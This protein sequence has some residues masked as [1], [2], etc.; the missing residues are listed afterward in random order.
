MKYHYDIKLN[1][2]SHFFFSNVFDEN[3]TGIWIFLRRSPI[4][5]Y[6]KHKSGPTKDGNHFKQVKHLV[7]GRI[8]QAYNNYLADILGVGLDGESKNSGF[9]SNQ[10]F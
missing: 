9:S 4:K 3:N 5:L 6:Q 8:K 10:L 1:Y 7:Q 2:F